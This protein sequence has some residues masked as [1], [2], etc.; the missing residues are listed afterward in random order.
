MGGSGSVG[1]KFS[2]VSSI[3]SRSCASC[4]SNFQSYGTLTSHQVSACGGDKLVTANDSAHSALLEL[5]LG[6][7]SILMPR[8]CSRAPCFSTTDIQ[9]ITDW[10]NEGAPNN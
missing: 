10:I 4:H 7:C 2:Q 1:V 3:V 6:Q 9:T 8:G 5:V